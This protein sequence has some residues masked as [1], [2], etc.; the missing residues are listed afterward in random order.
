LGRKYRC[1]SQQ[2]KSEAA[3][4][5]SNLPPSFFAPEIAPYGHTEKHTIGA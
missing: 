3:G 5:G 4:R 2:R 1:R